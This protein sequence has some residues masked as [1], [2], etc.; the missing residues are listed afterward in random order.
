MNEE[1][2]HVVESVKDPTTYPALTYLWVVALS[3]WGGAVRFLRK[4]RAGEMSLAHA[5]R[6][7]IG[8][9]VTSAFAGVMTFYLCEAS[10]ITGMWTAVMVGVAGHMGG[11]SLEAMESFYKRWAG[12]KDDQ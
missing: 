12:G 5:F 6:S 2:R 4:I 9:A 1:I 8:E 3:A 10:G 7:L 11:R